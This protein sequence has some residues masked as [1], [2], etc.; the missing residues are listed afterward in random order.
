[1]INPLANMLVYTIVFSLLLQIKP[2]LG[3]PSGLNNYALMLLAAMLPWN[4]FQGSI[5][6]SMGA[7]LGQPE[8][9]P[10]DVFP[11]RAHPGGDGGL[12]GRLPPDRDGP[13]PG[14]RRRVR[15]LEGARS[16]CPGHRD[17]WPW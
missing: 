1:M 10:E 14:G 12:Q 7:L 6:E 3:V 9:H 13:A 15:Q 2:P 16:S 11:P 17:R 5:M 4:F 8:P